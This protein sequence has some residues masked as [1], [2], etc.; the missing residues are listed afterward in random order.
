[1]T[2]G[3]VADIKRARLCDELV[4]IKIFVKQLKNPSPINILNSMNKFNMEDLQHNIRISLGILLNMQ[5]F[6]TS[7]ERSFS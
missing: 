6:V 5:V 2:I 1:L 4:I 7:G 3:S